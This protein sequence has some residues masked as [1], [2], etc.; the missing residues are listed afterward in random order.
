MKQIPIISTNAPN[1]VSPLL[2]PTTHVPCCRCFAFI[3][4]EVSRPTSAPLCSNLLPA[5]LLL[6]LILCSVRILC[7]HCLLIPLQ[8]SF[9]PLIPCCT[10]LSSLSNHLC[11]ALAVLI[12]L[13]LCRCNT[14]QGCGSTSCC[15]LS[16]KAIP[17][18]S[19]PTPLCSGT[20]VCLLERWSACCS[21]SSVCLFGTRARAAADSC[22][23]AA[24]ASL[25]D[26]QPVWQ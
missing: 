6:P 26:S 14:Q 1:Q 25:S 23:R 4:F 5:C 20:M 13:L 24:S 11:F 19:A 12:R 15:L 10:F 16:S 9:P 18:V 2:L 22:F 21:S 7:L 8:L 17:M 3:A